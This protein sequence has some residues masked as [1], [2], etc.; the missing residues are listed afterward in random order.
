MQGWIKLHRQFTEWEWYDHNTTKLIFIHLLFTVNWKDAKW[1]GIDV[2]AGETVK[3]LLTLVE[4]S[5]FTLQNWRTAITNLKSTGEL[6]ERKVGKHRILK[7]KN[8]T[9]YQEGNTETNTETNTVLT[10]KEHGSNTEVT[11]IEEGKKEKKVRREEGGEINSPTP[12]KQAEDFFTTDSIQEKLIDYYVGLHNVSRKEVRAEIDRFVNYWTEPTPS[13][14]KVRWQTEKTFSVKHRLITW[15][16][17]KDKF[18][19]GGS[20]TSKSTTFTS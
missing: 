7:L 20:S 4:T 1:R 18:R 16:N 15:F 2:E 17:N 11:H 10:Q 8:Y 3:S 19:K 9:M 5:P 6:T 12:K 14:R 13:G